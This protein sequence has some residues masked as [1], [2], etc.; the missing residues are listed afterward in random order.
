MVTKVAMLALL[1]RNL[2]L[3]RPVH[4]APSILLHHHSCWDQPLKTVLVHAL[5]CSKSSLIFQ[6]KGSLIIRTVYLINTIYFLTWIAEYSNTDLK[7]YKVDYI[8]RK[9]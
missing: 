2:Y 6:P 5:V 1:T 7:L 9:E 4:M 3:I 8:Q